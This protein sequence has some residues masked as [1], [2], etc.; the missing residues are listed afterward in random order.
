MRWPPDTSSEAPSWRSKP[1]RGASASSGRCRNHLI[2][3]RVADQKHDLPVRDHRREFA[4]GEREHWLTG[5]PVE[6][7]GLVQAEVG[8]IDDV[9]QHRGRAID[10]PPGRPP[11]RAQ[12]AGARWRGWWGGGGGGGGG[13]GGGGGA[14]PREPPPR[15]ARRR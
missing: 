2:D 6:A 3:R 7:G 13:R 8:V 11:A 12:R 10:P 14:Q 9:A 5:A 4:V 15:R 1:R